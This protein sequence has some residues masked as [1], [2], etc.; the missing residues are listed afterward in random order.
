MMMH[1]LMMMMSTS[2]L[3][4]MMMMHLLIPEHLLNPTIQIIIRYSIIYVVLDLYSYLYDCMIY[5]VGIYIFLT[6]YDC[7]L[8]IA[9][10]S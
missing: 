3:I 1:L 7:F 2:L 6:S 10:W 5:I 9:P 4:V 8:Y